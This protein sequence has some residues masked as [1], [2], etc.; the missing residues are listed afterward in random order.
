VAYQDIA[1]QAVRE[2][3]PHQARGQYPT[4]IVDSDG[5]V[6]LEYVVGVLDALQRAGLVDISLT[7]TDGLADGAATAENEELALR[8]RMA[9]SGIA[10]PIWSDLSCS[11]MDLILVE[12]FAALGPN[13]EPSGFDRLTKGFLSILRK[14]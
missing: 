3:R 5:S 1:L 7:I 8:E 11:I 6:P 13:S 10:E 2:V 9:E 12:D 4:V 14:D